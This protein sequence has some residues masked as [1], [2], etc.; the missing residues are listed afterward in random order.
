MMDPRKVHEMIATKRKRGAVI[1]RVRSFTSNSSSILSDNASSNLRMVVEDAFATATPDHNA[2]IARRT[3]LSEQFIAFSDD[4]WARAVEI[5]IPRF[6]DA[7]KCALAALARRPY[8]TGAI[9][10]PFRAPNS[11]RS[12]ALIRGQWLMNIT[13][14][15]G[16][17]DEDMTWIA[18]HGA[19]LAGYFGASD[20]GWLLA[21]AI[22]AQN[23]KSAE[24]REILMASARGEHE[25]GSMGRHVT[26]ALMCAD[27]SQGW[28]FVERLLIAAQREEGTRQSIL[29]SVDESHPTAFRRML[30]LIIEERLARFSSLVRAADTWFGFL[31]DG[32]SAVKVDGILSRVL[33]FLDDAHARTRALGEKDPETAYLALWTLAFDDVETVIDPA[34]RLLSANTAERR[35]VATH[36]LAQTAWPTAIPEIVKML[37]DDDHRVAARALRAFAGNA[38]AHVDGVTLFDALERLIQSVPKRSEALPAIVWPWNATTLD[39]S[40][41]AAAMVANAGS[42]V[43]ARVLPFVSDLEPLGRAAFVRTAAGVVKPGRHGPAAPKR[44]LSADE[45]LL[46]ID[47]LGDASGDVRTAAFEA[48]ATVTLENDEVRRL[49]DLLNRKPGD[50]RNAAIKRLSM[51]GDADLLSAAD[52]LITDDNELRRQAG[53]ELLRVAVE[54]NRVASE[55]RQRVQRYASE[56][57]VGDDVERKHIEAIVT[58][59]PEATNPSDVLGLIEETRL[60]QWPTPLPRSLELETPG[61]RASLESLAALV[62]AN[63]E[64]EVV[65]RGGETSHLIEALRFHHRAMGRGDDDA[66]GDALPLS[67][68]WKTW[69]R[70]RDTSMRDPD[71]AELLRLVASERTTGMWKSEVVQTVCGL[72]PARS[73][74]NILHVLLEWGVVWDPPAGGFNLLLD[75]LESSIADFTD[76]DAVA[77]HGHDGNPAA[78]ALRGERTPALTALMAKVHAV[79]RF[80]RVSRWWRTLFP[81]SIQPAQTERFYGLLRSFQIRTGGRSHFVQL[82]DFFAAYDAG[83]VDEVEFLRLIAGRESHRVNTSPLRQVSTR[84]PSAQLLERPKLLDVVDTVRRRVVEIETTRGERETA[85]SILANELRWSGG[86]EALTAAVTALGKTHFARSFSWQGSAKSRQETLSQIVVRSIPRDEDTLERFAEWAKTAHVDEERL[87][88]LAVYAP[89]W[90]AHVNHVLNWP[91]LE[92]AVWWI[93]A[94]T[95]DDRS[96][97]LRELKEVWA[98]EISERTPLAPGDLTE[99]GVDVEWFKKVYSE[100]GEKRWER[101]DKAAKYAA[102]STGH[103]RARLFSQALAGLITRDEI[104]ERID[105]S[106]HQDAVRALGLLPLAEGEDRDADLL[107]RYVRLEDFKRE[108]RKFGSAR[109]QSE[110]RAVAIAL[111]NLARTAGFRDTQR[112]RWAMEQRAVADLAS[113]P[114]VL[115]RD[116]VTATLSIDADG[117]PE[118]G[119]SK[120]GKP[121]KAPP[122]SLKND[123]E[124]KALKDRLQDLKRQSSRVNVALEEAMCRGDRF[125]QSELRTLVEHP[126]LAPAIARLVF[127]GDDIAGYVDQGG[128]IL[129]DYDGDAHIIGADEGIRI[130]HPHDLLSRGDWSSWQRECFAAERIQPF[131]QVFRELY[132][133]TDSER[134]TERSRRYAGH[135][136]NPRQALALLGT[137]GWVARPEEGVSRTF[138]DEGLTTWLSFEESFNTPAEVEGLTLDDVVFTQKGTWTVVPLDKVPPRVFSEAMRDLDLVV[139]VAHRG[140]VD[141]EATASTVEMRA[142]L[143]GETCQLLDI[144]NVE[145]QKH[146]AIIRGDLATYSIH[147]G[148]GGV[149]VMPG[150]AIP[151]VA[152]RSQH[153]GRLFLPFADNDPRTAEVL[154]KVLL[155]ARDGQIRDPN[156]LQWIRAARAGAPT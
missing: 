136:V 111:D 129:R 131:K 9:R 127:V 99:G 28:E 152:V 92:A 144:K 76:E 104:I 122:A 21:G 69:V 91:G 125:H 147:L 117:N 2:Y 42:D 25:V 66:R 49:V 60:R 30:R 53:L 16:D 80:V 142:S 148:S 14:I 89:Q 149:M 4:D 34:V 65:N 38:T 128:R 143:V 133:I 10:K 130:A 119:V 7:A 72:G 86:L 93:E 15:L 141:P 44:S 137:R 1:E 46:A 118:L 32:A 90:A 47:L 74:A 18:A 124:F 58:G 13:R 56:Q 31:W 50:L 94:H 20:L 8:Q 156:I 97:Q 85:A 79:D 153:R 37:R 6:A 146:H 139:S 61:A 5:L 126:I 95:K 135:Q 43:G 75:G 106:R 48:M 54:N 73:G 52:E 17:F 98:A 70:E 55:A 155:F 45:R 3:K 22:D 123:D 78:A 12:L 67:S 19:Y 107:L 23:D 151:V 26:S 138:H 35:F 132:P 64:T 62:M 105:K 77:M 57:R 100:I 88:E 83:I 71:G 81:R 102:S 121:L 51:L 114:I 82:P 116:D 150:T 103:T 27:D 33:E 87:L 41:I 108:A 109:Q 84:R 36:L 110:S 63:A 120:N 115:T 101:L 113:G 39:R 112:L 140:G 154:S 145:L 134:G 59:K 68:V 11:K 96:W 40:D 24:V 29:E